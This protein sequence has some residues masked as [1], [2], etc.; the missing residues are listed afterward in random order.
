[1]PNKKNKNKGKKVPLVA[2]LAQERVKALNEERKKIEEE[3]ERIRKEEE[4]ERRKEEEER[5]RIEEEKEKKKERKKEKKEQLKKEGKYRTAGQIKKDK[6]LE[7]IRKQFEENNMK[8]VSVEKKKLDEEE[9]EEVKLDSEIR[10]PICCVLGHVDTGKTKLL[11]NIR[12]SNVQEGEAAGITQQIGATF[13]PIE[14]IIERTKNARDIIDAEYNI[15]GLLII[16]TPGHESFSNLRIRGNSLCDVAIL[17]VDILHGIQKQTIESIDILKKSKTPF[18]IALNKIDRLYNWKRKGDIVQVSVNEQEEN[19]VGEFN[20]RVNEVK[21]SLYEFGLISELYYKNDDYRRVVSMV[22][23]SSIT[24][25]GIPELL[26]FMVFI[27]K[28]MRKKI[29]YKTELNCTI[30]DIKSVDGIGTTADVILSNGVLREGDKILVASINGPIITSV[31]GL[32]TPEPLS[33]L[34]GK[35]EYIRNKE[36]IGAMGIKVVANDIDGAIA[37]TSILRIDNENEIEEKKNEI[38][39]EI[40]EIMS[41]YKFDKKGVYIK[42]S[43]MGSFDALISLLRK[44]EIK[45]YNGGIGKIHK[46]DILKCSV[47]KDKEDLVILSFEVEISQD[48]KNLAKENSIKL[49]NDST[50][51]RLV[52]KYI[53]YIKELK[54][55]KMEENKEL[56]IYPCILEIDE[57]YIFRRK[58]PI[59]LGVKVESGI[60]KLNTPLYIDESKEELGKVVSLEL[61][62]KTVNEAKKGEM[63]CVKILVNEN[64]L[65]Y[66]RH[67]THKNKL[68]SKISRESIDFMKENYRN[69][70]SMEEW[71]LMRLIKNDLNIK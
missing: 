29:I 39:K 40:E 38:N 66:G 27:S 55:V 17:V 33:E 19:T 44:N 48:A 59:V 20:S 62:H 45:I 7:A 26:S 69:E 67:F 65:Y 14:K 12:R 49:L 46:K 41:N 32:L 70:L 1:M 31:K 35:N 21:N 5:K 54:K 60:L 9:I 8:M 51:Y 52:E 37:G 13:I 61:D 34:K 71:K 50:I 56:C 16:D 42:C 28:R 3:K 36:V 6:K 2:K 10:T 58:S 4:E 43:T 68:L 53:N 11:D 15:P 64:N 25:E 18:I 22:P 63:V 47:M 57:R 30:M 24:G 23:I